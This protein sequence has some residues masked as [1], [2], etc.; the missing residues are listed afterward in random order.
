MNTKSNKGKVPFA[1]ILAYGMGDVGCNFS[2]KFVSNFPMASNRLAFEEYYDE[3]KFIDAHRETSMKVI[4]DLDR[5]PL[6]KQN[7]DKR[8]YSCRTW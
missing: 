5:N 7:N 8:Q 4:V 3:Y 2:W 1:S 6:T